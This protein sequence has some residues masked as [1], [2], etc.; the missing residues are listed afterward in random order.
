M[1][2]LSPVFQDYFVKFFPVLPRNEEVMQQ[3]QGSATGEIAAQTLKAYGEW[4]KQSQMDSEKRAYGH[5]LTT[6]AKSEL[7]RLP[8]HLPLGWQ[9]FFLDLSLY[10]FP[11]YEALTGEESPV[12]MTFGE[13]P[14][15]NWNTQNPDESKK[16]YEEIYKT[17]NNLEMIMKKGWEI[18]PLSI[19]NSY[20]SGT[21][22]LDLQ[23]PH[24][25]TN[26][27]SLIYAYCHWVNSSGNLDK[28][29]TEDDLRELAS[30][31]YSKCGKFA[32]PLTSLGFNPLE[33]AEDSLLADFA[34]LSL[35]SSPL[36]QSSAKLHK[37]EHFFEVLSFDEGFRTKYYA[38][39]GE[40]FPLP[41]M[42]A[43]MV[44]EMTRTVDSSTGISSKI[45]RIM[46][47]LN[48][49]LQSGWTSP[50]IQSIY[51][52]TPPKINPKNP[53]QVKELIFEIYASTLV[54][55]FNDVDCTESKEGLLEKA[56]E[57]T[58]KLRENGSSIKILVLSNITFIPLEIT[59]L[60]NLFSLT[61]CSPF[62]KFLPKEIGRLSNLEN[63]FV[64]GGQLTGLPNEIGMLK[65]LTQLSI[66]GNKRLARVPKEIG[67][68]ENLRSLSL[69]G[70][71][72][73]AL[74]E[75]V[76]ALRGLLELNVSFNLLTR[77]PH[78]IQNMENLR[79]LY[80]NSNISF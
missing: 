32:P 69:Q 11:T 6:F 42:A 56:N 13:G 27:I 45:S 46:T 58:R 29:P 55:T 40:P 3:L 35:S 61:I 51:G 47:N 16:N 23:Q 70:N 30:A 67:R 77:L 68:L 62:L 63:L 74:P 66:T 79:V 19:R 53:E 28:P 37:W 38:M 22:T 50:L 73:V 20:A 80:F 4:L 43:Q 10:L 18:L 14:F 31:I 25:T 24:E 17:L 71:G 34:C 54:S 65:N 7:V 41:G 64:I 48:G 75:Q 21:P 72:L 33:D 78:S 59:S 12:L 52:N 2:L 5:Q 15:W 39:T 26:L 1:Q 60:E 8:L 44:L 57:I 76:G 9:S 49:I 36:A